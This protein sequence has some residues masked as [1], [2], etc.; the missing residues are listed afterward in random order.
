ML[1]GMTRDDGISQYLKVYIEKDIPGHGL[2]TVIG[3][4]GEGAAMSLQSQWNP[5]FENDT[6]GNTSYMQKAG[7][8]IQAGTGLTAKAEWNSLLNWVGIEPPQITM[9]I[10]LKAF[11]DAKLEVE[12]PI[13]FL[14]MMASPELNEISPLGRI[15]QP[16]LIDIGRKIKLIDCVIQDIQEELDSPRSKLGWRTE[17]TVQ[18]QFQ[19]KQMLNQ[20]EISNIHPN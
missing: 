15:P 20:S 16:C 19:M 8:A 2:V 12:D 1:V 6:V 11:S 14:K 10:V 3:Y 17:N 7:D 9:P 5:P 18:M 13:K 4:I